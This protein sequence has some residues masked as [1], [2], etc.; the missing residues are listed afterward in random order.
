M[1]SEPSAGLDAVA[2]LAFVIAVAEV[3]DAE[4]APLQRLTVDST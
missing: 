4:D 2:S 1:A 3:V